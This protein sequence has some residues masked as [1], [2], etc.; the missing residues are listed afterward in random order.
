MNQRSNN[1]R[2]QFIEPVEA[3]RAVQRAIFR[4]EARRHYIKNQE[5]IELPRAISPVVITV[6][7]ILALLLFVDG[8]IVTFWPLILQWK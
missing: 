6:L 4:D 1:H 7:W 3:P 5:K 8:L 2:N